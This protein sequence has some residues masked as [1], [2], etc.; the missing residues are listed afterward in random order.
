[1]QSVTVNPLPTVAIIAGGATTCCTGGTVTLT[2]TGATSYLWSRGGETT[3]EITVNASGT[4]SVVG[5]DGNGWQN[6]A[7]QSVTVNPLPTVAIS[8]DGPTTFCTGGTVTLTA[9]GAT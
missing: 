5:T 6:S 8:A 1:S 4:Y 2:A 7:S 3:D 9:T